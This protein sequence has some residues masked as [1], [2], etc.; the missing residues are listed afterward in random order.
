MAGVRPGGGILSG[1]ISTYR[2]DEQELAVFS[3]YLVQSSPVY[4]NS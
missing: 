1:E 2:R 4:I 3:L